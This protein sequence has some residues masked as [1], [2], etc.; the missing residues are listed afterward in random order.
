MQNPTTIFKK[1]GQRKEAIASPNAMEEKHTPFDE[2]Q[3]DMSK[4][5][6]MDLK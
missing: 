5:F 6:F 4:E 3:R 1:T 2:F